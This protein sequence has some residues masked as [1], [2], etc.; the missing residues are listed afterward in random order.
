MLFMQN[1]AASGNNTAFEIPWN[2]H[3]T[4]EIFHSYSSFVCFITEFRLTIHFQL[5]AINL[6]WICALAA[7]NI[8]L[9]QICTTS[10]PQCSVR[11]FLC[12]CVALHSLL[13]D[14]FDANHN[15]STAIFMNH[16]HDCLSESTVPSC[17]IIININLKNHNA[18]Y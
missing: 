11:T 2:L 5:P 3:A 16:V 9:M 1:A 15:H 6:I 8:L 18:Y 10:H 13:N 7:S 12:D 4:S 17:P 14:K